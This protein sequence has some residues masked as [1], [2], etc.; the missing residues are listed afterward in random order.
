MNATPLLLPN[1]LPEKPSRIAVGM[2]GGV[3]KLLKEA[4]SFIR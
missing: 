2:S 1:W 4:C 3:D